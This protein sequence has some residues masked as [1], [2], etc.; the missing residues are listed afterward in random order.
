MFEQADSK[1]AIVVDPF[2][3]GQVIVQQLVEKG[4]DVVAVVAD[5]PEAFFDG[6]TYNPE[7]LDDCHS[8]IFYDGS[9]DELVAS[10]RALGRKF[11]IVMV[12]SATGMELTDFLANEFGCRGNPLE[13]SALRHNKSETINAVRQAGLRAPEQI[14]ARTWGEV[15]SALAKCVNNMDVVIK[16]SK[17]G[18]GDDVY[19]C[20]SLEQVRTA[21][22][23]INGMEN[24][25]GIQNEGI[26][27]S[28]LIRGPE[29][30]VDVL[31]R[32]GEHKVCS[33]WATDVRVME[34]GVI[35]YF[36]SYFVDMAD[37]R[38]DGL[39]EYTYKVLDAMEV[40]NGPAT[41]DVVLGEDGPVL[42][43]ADSRCNGFS[44]CW[45]PVA[46]RMNGF[47]QITAAVSLYT[48]SDSFSKIPSRPRQR[49]KGMLCCLV[50]H[51]SGVLYDIPGEILVRSLP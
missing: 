44:G 17:S 24:P 31:S 40:R 23:A 14:V 29:Y 46:Q 26:M 42:I 10:L 16:P 36:G 6:T 45:V 43:G 49:C 15:E 9:K 33:I 27:I 13:S 28:E 8:T 38:F 18:G 3:A 25:I 2:S 4:Y 37:S 1:A 21:F 39:V 35:V 7:A 41:V 22:D 12:G 48:D 47:D 30:C 50:S 19:R 20:Q 11:D 5:V 51:Q 32:D 34:N